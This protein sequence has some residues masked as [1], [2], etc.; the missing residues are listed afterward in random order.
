MRTVQGLL[1]DALA[2][3]LRLPAVSVTVAGRTD[4]GV[5]ATGQVAHVDLPAEAAGVDL[6]RRL[7][8]VL[9][10]YVRVRSARVAPERFDARF[11][12]LARVYRYR[13]TDGFPDPLRR[14]D[15]LAWPRPLDEAVMRSAADRLLGEHDFAAYCRPRAGA[16]TVRRLLRL[17]VERSDDLVTLTVEADAFCHNMV[18]AIVG[19][20]LAVGDGRRPVHWPGQVLR[21]G[22]RDPGVTVAPAHGLT[23]VEVRYPPDAD[24]AART[25]VARVRREI[26]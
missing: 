12:A 1:E 2:Q 10:D 5:H 6:A 21:A 25:Q 26:G 15:T 23:L 4:A 7:N 20:L 11:S 18:R 16:T 14:H 8:G 22:V 17:D 9:P 24:L 3:V 19:A 13:V